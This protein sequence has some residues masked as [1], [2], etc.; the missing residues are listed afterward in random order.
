VF[1]IRLGGLFL[2]ALSLLF[3]SAACKP[4]HSVTL[5]PTIEEPDRP[6]AVLDMRDP[7]AARQLVRGFHRVEENSWRWTMGH[8]AVSLGTPPG[9]SHNGASVV[10]KFSIPDALIERYKTI[11]LSAQLDDK[12]LSP[13]TYT[14]SGACEYRRDAPAALLEKD[15]VQV[16]FALDK[17]LAAG[18]IE[19]RELGL[20]VASIALEPK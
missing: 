16:Q 18:A 3:P 20:V 5:E 4:N 17:Y 11:T 1:S 10:M 12:Q 9:A 2:G 19:T 13:E 14:R 7:K 15:P 8:F 6:L